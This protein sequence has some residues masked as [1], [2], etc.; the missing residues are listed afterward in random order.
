MKKGE[1]LQAV[2]ISLIIICS[3]FVT[4]CQPTRVLQSDPAVLESIRYVFE[5]A[6]FYYY[7][8]EADLYVVYDRNKSQIGHAF[9]AEGMGEGIS[10]TEMEAKIPGP[11]IIMVGLDNTETIKSIFVISNSETKI[12]WDLLVRNDYFKQFEGLAIEDA[13]FNYVG[14]A[15]DSVSGAT[16]SC[17]LVLNTVRDAA[18][19]KI[20]YIEGSVE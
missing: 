8:E 5:E 2:F 10:S 7:N 12:F 14:G 20:A 13:Y 6:Y 1:T 4:G 18:K 3:L 16:I 11:I 15:I 19:E 9:Y 17:K